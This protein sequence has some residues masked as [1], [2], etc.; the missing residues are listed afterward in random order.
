M[1]HRHRTGIL[2]L[3]EKRGK[4]PAVDQLDVAPFSERD[5]ILGKATRGHNIAAG[6]VLCGHD[7][8][9]FT[10]DGDGDLLGTPLF[11]LHQETFMASRQNEIDAAV[12]RRAALFRDRNSA[13]SKSFADELLELLPGER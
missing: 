11:T 6:G 10:H 4:L 12:R 5:G 3:A 1:R 13:L 9:Q 2:V 8:I 7:T